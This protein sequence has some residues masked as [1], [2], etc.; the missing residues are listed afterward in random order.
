[1]N[2]ESRQIVVTYVVLSLLSTFASSFIWGINTLFL[3]DAGLTV[4][5][6]FAANAFFTGGQVLF[7]IPTGI[8]AD[9]TGRRR[10]F[11]LGSATLLISTLVYYWLWRVHGPFWAWALVSIFLGLGFTFFSGATEAWL[12]DGLKAAGYDGQ[13]DSVFAKGSI[14][15]GVAMLTGTLAGGFVAQLTSL[16]VPYLMRVAALG[17]TFVLAFLFMHDDGFKPKAKTSVLKEMKSVFAD[18]VTFGFKKAPVRWLMLSG[19]FTGGV[20]IYAFYAMQ[21]HLLNLYGDST[22]YTV[23]GISA[24]VVAGAQI[25][26]GFLVPYAGRVFSKR[27]SFFIFGTALGV[28]ALALIGLLGNFYL[29]VAI[30]SLWSVFWAANIPIRQSYINQLLPS[31]QRA[32]ILSCD[33]MLASAGGVVA[34]PILGKTADV[35]G[36]PMSYIGSAIFQFLAL[37]FIVL[38]KT[39]KAES[40]AFSSDEKN[41]G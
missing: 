39:E 7:E 2:K 28:I 29:V 25:V 21:P 36:Y 14:A 40:D 5:E 3:L 41:S 34:Q 17:L 10:S 38:A 15:N 6:A 23:A 31:E 9:T 33:N 16:G 22:S 11:L 24:T 18:S 8:V 30:F 19:V 27:T 4:T 37:P 13:L 32:T 12:V 1:M 35:Y 20:G 26:G